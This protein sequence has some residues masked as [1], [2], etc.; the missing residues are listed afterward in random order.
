MK[1]KGNDGV[2]EQDRGDHGVSNSSSNT[3]LQD[4]SPAPDVE[5]RPIS[6]KRQPAYLQDY[7]SGEGLG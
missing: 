5:G 2:G 1:M 3:S 4:A 7:V 6:D